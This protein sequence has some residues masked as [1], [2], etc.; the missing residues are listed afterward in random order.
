[1]TNE[2]IEIDRLVYQMYNLNEDDIKEVEN[3]FFRRYPK[4]ARVIEG[5]RKVKK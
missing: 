5:K 3:W 1:M 2:Q 4:L